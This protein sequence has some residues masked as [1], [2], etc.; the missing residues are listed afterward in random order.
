MLPRMGLFAALLLGTVSIAASLSL[1]CYNAAQNSEIVIVPFRA[2]YKCTVAAFSGPVKKSDIYYAFDNGERVHLQDDV[3][4]PVNSA[5]LEFVAPGLGKG[6]ALSFLEVG[7]LSAGAP[8]SVRTRIVYRNPANSKWRNSIITQCRGEDELQLEN[9]VRVNANFSC[10]L[11][12][13]DHL[14]L[15]RAEPALFQVNFSSVPFPVFL[16]SQDSV[17][18]SFFTTRSI[19]GSLETSTAAT[20]L[21]LVTVKDSDIGSRSE[22]LHAPVALSVNYPFPGSSSGIDCRPEI[23]RK[24]SA[25]SF[26]YRIGFQE[27]LFCSLIVRGTSATQEVFARRS[28]VRLS[29]LLGFSPNLGP[30]FAQPLE[31]DPSTIDKRFNFTVMP[32]NISA[33]FSV[34]RQLL[35]ANDT[36]GN[37]DRTL[38]VYLPRD[39]SAGAFLR[40]RVV[41]KPDPEFTSVQCLGSRS[42][43]VVRS[44]V[45]FDEVSRSPLNGTYV[46]QPFRWGEHVNCTVLAV[47]ITQERT[48]AF[49]FSFA[50]A[51][52]SDRSNLDSGAWTYPLL[53]NGALDLRTADFTAPS[54]SSGIASRTLLI[55]TCCCGTPQSFLPANASECISKTTELQGS[56]LYHT[57]TFVD[58]PSPRSTVTCSPPSGTILAEGQVIACTITARSADGS[59]VVATGRDF[60]YQI[61]HQ[62]GGVPGQCQYIRLPSVDGSGTQ[63]NFS[64][65]A[66]NASEPVTQYNLSVFV[67]SFPVRLEP[68]YAL[69]EGG[70]FLYAVAASEVDNSSSLA[71]S[72]LYSGVAT[73]T[74]NGSVEVSRAVVRVGELIKCRVQA[75]LGARG[76]AVLSANQA[77]FGVAT[78]LNAPAGYQPTIPAPS[79]ETG[80]KEFSFTFQAPPAATNFSVQGRLAGGGR[81]E[82]VEMIEVLAV[83]PDTTS[84][85]TCVSDGRPLLF[86]QSGQRVQ[87]EIRA[88]HESAPIEAVGSDFRVTW[89]SQIAPNVSVLTSF[90]EGSHLQHV[91]SFAFSVPSFTL[92]KTLRIDLDVRS[93]ATG[94]YTKATSL[95]F[96]VVGTPEIHSSIECA[97]SYSGRFARDDGYPAALARHGE[98]VNC[99]ISSVS[100]GAFGMAT[101]AAPSMFGPVFLTPE[102]GV[103]SPTNPD[104]APQGHVGASEFFFDFSAPAASV[105]IT[106][107]AS[108][109]DG[110]VFRDLD[111][112]HVV[113]SYPTRKSSV[114]CRGFFGAISFLRERQS[115]TCSLLAKLDDSSPT[116][117]SWSDFLYN[118]SVISPGSSRALGSSQVF[119][120]DARNLDAE[121][122]FTLVGP[123]A[124][125]S[126]R[127]ET[128]VFV[129]E[130]PNAE[131]ALFW[132]L[133][134]ALLA[135]PNATT[136]R[137]HC[138]G[139][140]SKTQLIRSFE[141]ISCTIFS[142]AADGNPAPARAL[143]FLFNV[144]DTPGRLFDGEDIQGAA[145]D[146]FFNFSVTPQIASGTF[147]IGAFVCVAE[148]LLPANLPPGYIVVQDRPCRLTP[149][150][151]VDASFR[152]FP[153]LLPD[154]TLS[155]VKV[156]GASIPRGTVTFL[157][158]KDA[159]VANAS[160]VAYAL[161]APVRNMGN[162]TS[163][164]SF[165]AKLSVSP[166]GETG[167]FAR[168]A[169]IAEILP[170]QTGDVPATF[171]LV[172]PLDCRRRFEISLEY[173]ASNVVQESDENNNGFAFSVWLIDCPGMA[174][175]RTAMDCNG[176]RSTTKVIKP[177]EPIVC[178]VNATDVNGNRTALALP[179]DLRLH[180]S[181]EL[182]P[183]AL[184]QESLMWQPSSGAQLVISDFCLDAHGD[185]V[186]VGATNGS[187]S[188]LANIDGG[189]SWLGFVA[190][191]RLGLIAPIVWSSA[192]PVAPGGAGSPQTIALPVSCAT[193]SLLQVWVVGSLVGPPPSGWIV[194][195]QAGNESGFVARLSP[196]TGEVAFGAVVGVSGNDTLLALAID[197]RDDIFI[198]GRAAGGG[199]ATEQGA[200]IIKI[201]SNGEFRELRWFKSTAFSDAALFVATYDSDTLYSVL[202]LNTTTQLNASVTVT[203][204]AGGADLVVISHH[205]SN[206]GLRWHVQLAGLQEEQFQDCAVDSRGDVYVVGNALAQPASSISF[207][208]QNLAVNQSA[209]IVKITRSGAVAWVKLLELMTA[210]SIA[211]DVYDSSFV[212]SFPA[213]QGGQTILLKSLDNGTERYSTSLQTRGGGGATLVRSRALSAEELLLVLE[214]ASNASWHLS[215]LSLSSL[216]LPAPPTR[217]GATQFLIE[218]P[219]LDESTWFQVQLRLPFGFTGRD[220]HIG[221][222]PLNVTILLQLQTD[223]TVTAVSMGTRARSVMSSVGLL[224][225]NPL[226]FSVGESLCAGPAGT[227]HALCSDRVIV[228]PLNITATNVFNYTTEAPSGTRTTVRGLAVAQGSASVVTTIV[229]LLAG[230]SALVTAPLIL[231]RACRE[232]F[233]VSVLLDEGNAVAETFEDNNAFS[234]SLWL[235]GCEDVPDDR[236]RV[237]CGADG[238]NATSIPRLQ[239]YSCFVQGARRGSGGG[240][241]TVQTNASDFDVNSALLLSQPAR[242]HLHRFGAQGTNPRDLVVDH[243]NGMAYLVG[244]TAA[245]AFANTTAIGGT[246]IFLAG[247]DTATFNRTFLTLLGTPDADSSPCLVVNTRSEVWIAASVIGPV[248]PRSSA[249]SP[250]DCAIWRAYSNGTVEFL[251]LLDSQGVDE[252]SAMAV[253]GVDYVYLVGSTTGTALPLQTSHSRSIA[254]SSFNIFLAKF[255]VNGKLL[256]TLVDGERNNDFGVAV[257][258]YG[259]NAIYIASLYGGLYAPYQ[260]PF[261]LIDVGVRG[262]NS[263]GQYLLEAPLFVGT[264]G[265][266]TVDAMTVDSSGSLYI[267][268][269]A[270][271]AFGE[272][273][274][275]EWDGLNVPF[276]NMGY[277]TKINATTMTTEWSTL[278]GAD[279][280]GM[281]LAVDH[282]DNVFVSG[283]GKGISLFGR[284]LRGTVSALPDFF[285]AGFTKNGTRL[286]LIYQAEGAL[287]ETLGKIALDYSRTAFLALGLVTSPQV[288]TNTASLHRYLIAQNESLPLASPFGP[289][290]AFRYA[291]RTPPDSGQLFVTALVR[292]RNPALLRFTNNGAQN[293]MSVDGR[294]RVAG[295]IGSNPTAEAVRGESLLLNVV[296]EPG[297]AFIEGDR[298]FFRTP[299]AT[300][301]VENPLGLLIEHDKAGNW[302]QLLNSSGAHGEPNALF[303]NFTAELRL[304]LRRAG[305]T[306]YSNESRVALSVF[307]NPFISELLISPPELQI[308]FHR[309]NLSYIVPVPTGVTT[310]SVT[311]TLVEPASSLTFELYG[312]SRV[313]FTA[314]RAPIIIPYILAGEH[315]L[316]ITS[317][318]ADQVKSAA[319]QIVTRRAGF[320]IATISALSFP[321]GDLF[322]PVF[323]PDQTGYSISVQQNRLL[324]SFSFTHERATAVLNKTQILHGPWSGN[325][326]QFNVSGIGNHVVTTTID[327]I[328]EDGVTFMN[329]TLGVSRQPNDATLS[330][331]VL[332]VPPEQVELDPPFSPLVTE[333]AAEVENEVTSLRV[334]AVA[335]DR[336]S[337]ITVPGACNLVRRCEE[338]LVALS[339]GQTTLLQIN[340][341]ALMNNS[342]IYTVNVTR[343]KSKNASLALLEVSGTRLSSTGLTFSF[344]VSKNTST[345]SLRAIPVQAE[346]RM[347]F[348]NQVLVANESKEVELSAVGDYQ[349]QLRV[350]PP[351]DVDRGT[352]TNTVSYTLYIRRNGSRVHSL[353]K[354]DLDAGPFN[355]TLE[356]A[357]NSTVYRYALW[358]PN[359]V[360]WIRLRVLK[361]DPLSTASAGGVPLSDDEWSPPLNFTEGLTQ[362]SVN[363][364]SENGNDLTVYV[365]LVTRQPSVAPPQKVKTGPIPDHVTPRAAHAGAAAGSR[366]YFCGGYGANLQPLDTCDVFDAETSKWSTTRLREARI[367]PTGVAVANRWV[368]VA[369]GRSGTNASSISS[370]VDVFDASIPSAS[371]HTALQ[372][373]GNSALSRN[374]SAMAAASIG[375]LAFFGGGQ[376]FDDQ[377]KVLTESALVEVFDPE[378]KELSFTFNLS[379]ARAWLS[380]TATASGLVIFAGGEAAGLK[381]C[382]VDVYQLSTNSSRAYSLP[383]CRS[384]M[385][386]TSLGDLAFFF[387]GE[388]DGGGF[389]NRLDIFNGAMFREPILFPLGRA[390]AA[391]AAMPNFVFFIGG[392]SVAGLSSSIDVYR[393][394]ARTYTYEDASARAGARAVAFG[395]RVVVFGGVAAANGSLSTTMTALAAGEPCED[396][397]YC[398]LN[399]DCQGE[400]PYES[401]SCFDSLQ[402][403]RCEELTRGLFGVISFMSVAAVAAVPGSYLLAAILSM[404]SGPSSPYQ[405]FTPATAEHW[406]SADVGLMLLNYVWYLQLFILPLAHN[407]E[408]FA[409]FE[410]FAS[411]Q[412]AQLNSPS[413]SWRSPGSGLLFY[414]YGLGRKLIVVIALL[415]AAKTLPGKVIES[416][417]NRVQVTAGHFYPLYFVVAVP[418]VDSIFSLEQPTATVAVSLILI[419]AFMWLWVSLRICRALRTSGGGEPSMIRF[420]MIPGQGWEGL[421]RAAARRR[422]R[423][424]TSLSDALETRTLRRWWS[425]FR[426]EVSENRWSVSIKTAKPRA[427]TTAPQSEAA[428]RKQAAISYNGISLREWKKMSKDTL[429]QDDIQERAEYQAGDE[430]DSWLRFPYRTVLEPVCNY[431]SGSGEG[432]RRRTLLQRFRGHVAP[433]WIFV[434]I[435]YMLLY[436]AVAVLNSGPD[437]ISALISISLVFFALLV[438]VVPY[439]PDLMAANTATHA[440][441]TVQL[442]MWYAISVDHSRNRLIFLIALF[443]VAVFPLRIMLRRFYAFNDEAIRWL[444]QQRANELGKPMQAPQGEPDFNVEKKGRR[445]ARS[446]VEMGAKKRGNAASREEGA[447]ARRAPS[448]DSLA[449]SEEGRTNLPSKGGQGSRSR[450]VEKKIKGKAAHPRSSSRSDVV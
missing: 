195:A 421:S 266:D 137:C 357:F 326:T 275:T 191:L 89:M 8:E 90:A 378:R 279:S 205:S 185:L 271:S 17:V 153:N 280:R 232:R 112:V 344:A 162:Y 435:S 229:P 383:V 22:L 93:T 316:R 100:G 371:L 67:T 105:I 106:V 305:D 397:D 323:S 237:Q 175:P 178:L 325:V 164:L 441:L 54:K 227:S 405:T 447:D 254:G 101:P 328:A 74:E 173:D 94:A 68:E 242:T 7:V 415:V 29:N 258:V 70:T 30:E 123:A 99:R 154:L 330:S 372:G 423:G 129:K 432:T 138:V 88:M 193:N 276:S 27:T 215:V 46:F 295:L 69:L 128:L 176:K 53:G 31:G 318:A 49:N 339:S 130:P 381:S 108:L 28:E 324:V 208:G 234:F 252:P 307:R 251:V 163:E 75:R 146:V 300:C 398:N 373:S 202:T 158:A 45:P 194:S 302:L 426:H 273:N 119:N 196:M 221:Q 264:F 97:G 84:A 203:P 9:I 1:T 83:A 140:R 289:A 114:E 233:D 262:F 56:Y 40:L 356:P 127:L 414:S 245:G 394:D 425:R 294:F 107:Q 207:M 143:D 64:V 151:A 369:G 142:A 15:V 292:S 281:G 217:Q 445:A 231:P 442:C 246:D 141:S 244:T 389:S 116:L 308:P 63:F 228:F 283:W 57:M 222:Q 338:R 429:T 260:S 335:T 355:A 126:S 309:R 25:T 122:I 189:G 80:S 60:R 310:L 155:E 38:Q 282:Y 390:D 440:I 62:C 118:T 424:D 420:Y 81:F 13:R 131:F 287:G 449:S 166:R 434:E 98:R 296:P 209:F 285:L 168:F 343:L 367:G 352:L 433:Y 230:D 327:V 148:D 32:T 124:P 39:N 255:D 110:S 52:L 238:T 225:P 211:I 391:A 384:R 334:T 408:L 150:A 436:A 331:L 213:A 416:C 253:D 92:G 311:P 3:G 220:S 361:T 374:R 342:F 431:G 121:L 312:D 418:L 396:L 219:T 117:A 413:D 270:L 388:L 363:V 354:M 5:A 358:L 346:A 377:A 286:S 291:G 181:K 161:S 35:R 187:V 241:V 19:P 387:G 278:F 248:G 152:I 160:F 73:R 450:L 2:S 261:G 51:L 48:T 392:Q 33:I 290:G 370:I 306:F 144:S 249:A 136:S 120:E 216:L 174:S 411:L 443:M 359:G 337:S 303:I 314:N 218:V 347:L 299:N 366:G 72:G 190:K 267:A 61:S 360:T 214:R 41:S 350:V 364:L 345:V 315:V 257:C 239:N 243:I 34:P 109:A 417:F 422:Q 165:L 78:L 182:K 197:G 438:L 402:G 199:G 376:I 301:S 149:I 184:R 135:F 66:G 235:S 42:G 375:S 11:Q 102:D 400:Y 409:Q 113:A 224:P 348:N 313:R 401:C 198:A 353:D 410:A 192:L 82:S 24:P 320:S 403:A 145:G 439:R 288:T 59:P 76:S 284:Q 171:G 393:S 412:L 379:Q 351:F 159:I 395:N 169:E 134:F 333:Y 111:Y 167:G 20:V 247:Y 10:S 183:P 177:L 365:I 95:N 427:L 321:A 14:G 399:G 336:G 268:G 77:Y 12:A 132:E 404:G 6:K 448:R 263:S 240:S 226:V 430:Q 139:S 385:A 37:L 304:C 298:I 180:A 44:G 407:R 87:C 85:L 380:A 50:S 419:V 256:W 79:G 332:Q 265:H 223:L 386:A 58:E 341:T 186:I 210:S 349:F 23:S 212:T 156:N 250:A 274:K 91:F 147:D 444:L 340:V 272:P 317:V 4:E 21:G 26:T 368:V 319:Y 43:L 36:Y 362:I 329:Y 96:S 170:N 428:G 18:S 115:V 382:V 104:P 277:L 322:P 259:L 204:S 206:L 200:F 172:L 293:I 406:N 179:T 133:S 188:S 201:L 71:C 125:P 47:T 437:Q 86:L 446:R 157:S 103:S 269:S 236:T 55:V 65:A 16:Q 297:T